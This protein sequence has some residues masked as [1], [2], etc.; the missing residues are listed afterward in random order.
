MKMAKG[1]GRLQM[2]TRRV[3]GR[4]VYISFLNLLQF[5]RKLKAIIFKRFY[6]HASNVECRFLI[7][8]LDTQ[9]AL[10]FFL[11]PQLGTR[12][13]SKN[14]HKSIL[15]D[16]SRLQL[17]AMSSTSVLQKLNATSKRRWRW[18]KG[19][20]LKEAWLRISLH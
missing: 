3:D 10:K 5:A 1:F 9:H 18:E 15:V 14:T 19:D 7:F 8:A 11:H 4:D 13:F 12:L 2:A 16:S 17:R 20:F 6:D